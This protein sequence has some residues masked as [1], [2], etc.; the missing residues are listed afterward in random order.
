MLSFGYSYKLVL[1]IVCHF[2]GINSI[3]K[4]YFPIIDRQGASPI[5]PVVTFIWFGAATTVAFGGV[6]QQTGVLDP[7][8]EQIQ[9]VLGMLIPFRL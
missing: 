4:K 2:L 8:L 5:P 7:I 9:N 1:Y 3:T 6:L